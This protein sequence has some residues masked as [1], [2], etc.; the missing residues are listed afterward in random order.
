MFFVVSLA[1]Q[2]ALSPTLPLCLLYGRCR[3]APAVG[4]VGALLYPMLRLPPTPGTFGDA[5]SRGSNPL[6]ARSTACSGSSRRS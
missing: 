2:S 6:N 5:A 3:H 4:G 1:S